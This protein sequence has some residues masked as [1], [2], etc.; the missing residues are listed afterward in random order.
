[1]T[2]IQ[3]DKGWS[4]AALIA[5]AKHIGLSPAIIGILPRGPAELVEASQLVCFLMHDSQQCYSMMV[6]M[7]PN[8]GRLCSLA[9]LL[10]Q[11]FEHKCNEELASQLHS[12]K[13]AWQGFRMTQ[14][15][16]EG[17]KLRLQMNAPYIGRL[18][19]CVADGYQK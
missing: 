19:C 14:R 16:K 15:V 11:Y 2:R 12:K 8:Q 5:G 10:L 18:S 4:D 9:C 3:N 13:E 1:M 6:S 17:L 7:I